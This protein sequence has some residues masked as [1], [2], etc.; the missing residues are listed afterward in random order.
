MMKKMSTQIIIA[1]KM[2]FGGNCIGKNSGKT[3]FI[4]FAVPGEKLEIEITK[5]FRDY[6]EAKII[7]IL[8]PSPHRV[9]PFCPL[10]GTCGGCNMQ[11]IDTDYQRELRAAILKD[12]FER[13]GL[14]VPEIKIISGEDRNY[15]CRLQFHDGC[16]SQRESND[17]VPLSCCPVATKEINDYLAA[18]SVKDRPR[19]RVH[20]FGD[21]RVFPRSLQNTDSPFPRV[22]WAGEKEHNSVHAAA[23]LDSHSLGGKKIKNHV[24]PHFAGSSI[25]ESN[26]CAVNL[27]GKKISFDVQ[28]FFQSNLGVLEKTIGAICTNMGGKN[29]LDMY[30]GA[31]TFSVFLSS[32]FEKMT[33]VEHNRDA[34]VFA[35]MN[36]AGTKHESYGVSGAN[37]VKNNADSII[38][39]NGP[40]DAVIIDPPRSGMEKE[41]CDWLCKNK[42]GQIRS[43]SCDP[44]THARDAARLVKSGYNLAKL[45]LL[46]FYP[47]TSHIESLV[48][49]EYFDD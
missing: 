17:L 9:A 6:D 21:S 28:G 30:S 46:D 4:P 31:G 19:G 34:L 41:V 43:M 48:C 42:T 35:E 36:L 15:R 37:W 45:Y 13:E 11:H 8:E 10:Y 5:S 14:A 23:R 44:S 32:I 33:L 3:V 26:T 22:I 24:K 49:F 18:V 40:F 29:V 1:D 39:N 20:V 16:M 47:Q 12:C 38:K 7:S 27:C 25:N 2:V